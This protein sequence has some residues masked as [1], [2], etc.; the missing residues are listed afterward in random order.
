MRLAISRCVT[1]HPPTPKAPMFSSVGLPSASLRTHIRHSTVDIHINL[2]TDFL[3]STP[4]FI[5]KDNSIVLESPLMYLI[6]TA[7]RLADMQMTCQLTGAVLKSGKRA[8][9]CSSEL[10]V[11]APFF[12]SKKCCV[13]K[14]ISTAVACASSAF[15]KSSRNTVNSPEYR[16]RILSIRARWFTSTDSS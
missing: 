6:Q 9:E 4:I 7:S 16:A 12:I 1:C 10:S 13:S 5:T 11:L 2:R 14:S 3:Q 15:C 8:L